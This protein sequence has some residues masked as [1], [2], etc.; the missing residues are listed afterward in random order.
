MAVSD[1]R[2]KQVLVTGAGSGIGRATALAFAARGAN[3]VLSDIGEPA[4]DKIA[5]EVTALGRGCFAHVADVA[6]EGSMRTFS[7]RV[8]ERVGAIDVLVNNAGVA[9]IGNF[10]STPLDAWRRILDINVMGVVHGCHYFLPRM[11]ATAGNRQVVNVASL[12]GIAP[13]PNMSAYAASK[14]AVLGLC[15]V[16]SM[17]LT[18]SNV[19]VTAVCPGI[20]NTPITKGPKAESITD[21]QLAGLQAFY[22]AKGCDAD[23]VAEGIVDAVMTGREMLLVGPFARS[24]YHVKR[25]SRSLTRRLSLDNAKK[26]GFWSAAGA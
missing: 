16:L 20:I 10:T 2:N 26:I 17:E 22:R 24:M 11:L 9:Y 4:L 21:A 13:V 7:E 12:A 1:L 8:H 14:S 25:I 3:L 6:N 19:G 23:V 15:D 5:A 18:G